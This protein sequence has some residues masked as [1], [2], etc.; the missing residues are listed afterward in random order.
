MFICECDDLD[1]FVSKF[2]LLLT[3]EELRKKMGEKARTSVENIYNIQ[4]VVNKIE[5]SYLNM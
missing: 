5:R 2:D 4:E 3:D 1:C